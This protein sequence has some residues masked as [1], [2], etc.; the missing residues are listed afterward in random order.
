M[1]REFLKDK[2]VKTFSPFGV[3]LPL[4]AFGGSLGFTLVVAFVLAA[5]FPSIRLEIF[6]QDL[7]NINDTQLLVNS[8][9][10]VFWG[11]IAVVLWKAFNPNLREIFGFGKIKA[12]EALS[13]MGIF[14]GLQS[15][16][17]IIALILTSIFNIEL[18]SNGDALLSQI[19]IVKFIVVVILAPILE[20]VFFRGMLFDGFLNSARKHIP[21]KD[22]TRIMITVIFTSV[23]FG[24][25][26]FNG[27]FT[28]AMTLIAGGIL[29]YLRIK[30]GHLGLS[31][32]GHMS[33]NGFA[34]LLQSIAIWLSTQ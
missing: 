33:F 32:I 15:F 29:A 4:I 14:I 9:M 19:S 25:L 1:V 12:K 23:F 2:E 7:S 10:F 5:I 3:W 26:H 18:S 11:L 20:E 31:V 16:A 34:F 24:M 22:S 6:N 28:I 27:V 13:V 30:T 8:V 17:V 21:I